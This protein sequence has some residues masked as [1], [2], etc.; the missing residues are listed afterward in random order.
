MASEINTAISSPMDSTSYKSMSGVKVSR[1]SI[2]PENRIDVQLN[3]GNTADLY[4]SFCSKPNC[5]LDGMN[6]YLSFTYNFVGTTP[7]A[8]KF[9]SIANGTGAS[10]IKNLECIAGNTSIELIQDYNVL[11]CLVDDFQ[12]ND[13][14]RTLASI[15]QDKSITEVKKGFQRSIGVP[16][17]GVNADGFSQDR[18]ICLPLTSV[19][20]GT[21]M[22][23][24]F[25]MGRDVGL[26]L[27]LTLE[28]PIL[29]L[30][31]DQTSGNNLAYTLKDITYEACYLEVPPQ[32]Y[33]SIS[34]EANGVFKISGTGISSF[35]TTCNSNATSNTLLIPAR[36]SSVRNFFT[37]NRI[38]T[39]M[40]AKNANSLGWRARDGIS[41]YVYR[42]SGMN[43]PQLSV[44]VDAYTGAEAMT[45]V[46][47]CLHS[48]A[49]LSTSVC[50]SR[51]D[52][53]HNS[54][55]A[56]VIGI[57]F[58]EPC[59]SAS[60]M[61]GI[62]TTSGNVFLELGYSAP[63][64]ASTFNTFCFYDT[65]IEINSNGEVSVSK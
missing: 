59:F 23:K 40:I 9:A 30:F 44:S 54:Q 47:K 41:S 56:F 15:L 16:I 26:R 48:H 8:G 19:C 42:I 52:Y 62:N 61:S 32:I 10:F 2:Q 50:F 43:Y 6:S 37:T 49:N 22:D 24:Y 18:R 39:N 64:S 53:V 38:S 4:F 14:C 31:S 13:R 25:P 33:K 36:F 35:S 12:S 65:I 45:E 27:R 5:F 60:Q 34:D 28:D 7:E 58:E 21:M 51:D 57:D 11:A 63:C 3:Q 17:A 20:C 29:A 46:L 55:G 1:I